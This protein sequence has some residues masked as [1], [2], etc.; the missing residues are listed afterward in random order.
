MICISKGIHQGSALK[1]DT[2]YEMIQFEDEKFNH[3]L[4]HFD[5][6]DPEH[7]EFNL[8]FDCIAV[9]TDLIE[10]IVWG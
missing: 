10:E 9:A 3:Y 2:M 6:C 8:E 5:E 1:G 7:L 4:H